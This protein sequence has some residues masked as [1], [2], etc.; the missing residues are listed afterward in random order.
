MPV[1]IEDELGELLEVVL[2][3]ATGLRQARHVV[4]KTG[5]L[6]L[7]ALGVLKLL[8]LQ[9]GLTVPQLARHRGTTRQNI[10]VLVDRL[11]NVGWVE[12]IANPDHKRSGRLRL[13]S[14]GHEALLSVNQRQ[15]GWLAEMLPSVT[16]EELRD[17][18]ALLQRV[19][20]TLGVQRAHELNAGGRK[21]KSRASAKPSKSP[22]M[23][24]RQEGLE[25]SIPDASPPE[26][27]PVNL[28]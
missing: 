15:A 13:T 25:N 28:L 6:S 22:A 2:S 7:P 9:P 18:N 20:A 27:L 12:S 17:C 14:T 16:G 5:G 19:Q 8:N 24:E 10:Q 4:P 23:V 3:I 1:E 26:A 11:A 21:P